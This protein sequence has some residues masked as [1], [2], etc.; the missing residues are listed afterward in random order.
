MSVDHWISL[1]VVLI[2]VLLGSGGFIWTLTD[3]LSQRQSKQTDMLKEISNS[4]QTVKEEVADHTK[5]IQSL[6]DGQYRI[7][8]D[9]RKILLELDKIGDESRENMKANLLEQWEEIE[10]QGYITLDQKTR[11]DTCYGVYSGRGGNGQI[12]PI[13]ERVQQMPVVSKKKVFRRRRLN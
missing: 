13:N 11:W 6:S 3:K 7:N 4:V 2:P 12:K 10:A 9:N 8:D 1:L 5:S